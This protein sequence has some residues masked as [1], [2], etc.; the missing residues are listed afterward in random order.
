[1]DHRGSGLV[2]DNSLITVASVYSVTICT[3][4]AVNSVCSIHSY[5]YHPLCTL[6]MFA[7]WD[8]ERTFRPAYAEFN[9]PSPPSA[10]HALLCKPIYI[11]NTFV[12]ILLPSQAFQWLHYMSSA[13][14]EA[15]DPMFTECYTLAMPQV[16]TTI[17]LY[18][19]TCIRSK[20]E[21]GCSW[22]IQPNDSL[23]SSLHG[24]A[25]TASTTT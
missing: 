5:T 3:Q 13:W 20:W 1:M 9:A 11:L 19:C 8:V 25:S 18:T 12:G 15:H 17:Q 6:Q 2:V 14:T 7:S 10:A 23:C 21:Q 16:Y 24:S 22:N 4:V